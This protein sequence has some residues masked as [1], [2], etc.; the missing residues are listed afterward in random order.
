MSQPVHH[1]QKDMEENFAKN[2][3]LKSQ[4]VGLDNEPDDA[5]CLMCDDKYILPTN[6]KEYLTHLFQEHRLVIGEVWKI[7]SLKS[8]V[9]YWGFKFKDE[10][11]QNFC[12]TL[13]MDCTPDGTPSPGEFYFLLSDFLAEDKTLRE[14][15]HRAKLEWVI[16]QQTNERT[17]TNFRK[18]CIFC[19][20]EFHGSRVE[21]V[22]HLFQ[23]HNLYLGKPEN[24]VFLDD[25]FNKIHN[26]IESK[27]CI[28]CE[29]LFKDRTALKEHM[30]KKSHKRIN[31]GNKLYDKYYINN[32]LEP[33]KIWG[34]K[35]NN[36]G[37]DFSDEVSSDIE[38]GE[39]SWSDWNDDDVTI[40]CLFCS[41]VNKDRL[42][43]FD[44]MEKEHN[45]RFVEV[46][47]NYNFYHKIKIVNYIRRQIR[48]KRCIYCELE[49]DII[50]SHMSEE[51]H[52]KL[53]GQQIWDQPEYYFPTDE[54]DSF[55]Y[56]LDS[57]SSSDE[58]E[59]VP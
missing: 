9:H 50:L 8:Y 28:Y 44:H 52:F 32:Y 36:N 19:K 22:K 45:F 56:H 23:K 15:I 14:E 53:P 51:K 39:A 3:N 38:E 6:E 20:T 40:K 43:I 21:Y 41:H 46:L 49:S 17:D 13:L 26:C 24:L 42:I 35:Q 4:F 29:R 11:I 57:S 1:C 58:G 27:T 59:D 5:K 34:Q 2:C 16:Q 48:L 31:P 10:P 37:D 55:L 7:A 33:W 47:N 25:F 18:G 12:S 54:N 30:R